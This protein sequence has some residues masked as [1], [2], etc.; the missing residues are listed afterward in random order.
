MKVRLEEEKEKKRER[1]RE[2]ESFEM[3]ILLYNNIT[4]QII[5]IIIS[6]IIIKRDRV[7]ILT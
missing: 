3:K 1:E 4:A 2:R 6:I 5:T 7:I